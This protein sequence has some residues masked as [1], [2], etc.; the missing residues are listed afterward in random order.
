MNSEHVMILGVG[1]STLIRFGLLAYV[2][3]FFFFLRM[4]YPITFDTSAWYS[5][6]S[7][8]VMIAL[9]AVTVYAFRI[10]T[11]GRAIDLPHDPQT[12]RTLR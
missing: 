9:V 7:I 3:M 5:S 2:A 11:S 8:L 10:A 1:M 12:A 4:E 6:T